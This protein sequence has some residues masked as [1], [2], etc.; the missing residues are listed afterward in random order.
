MKSTSKY[1][2]FRLFTLVFLFSIIDNQYLFAQAEDTVYVKKG[3]DEIAK[4]NPAAFNEAIKYFNKANEINPSNINAY[5]Y[6]GMCYAALNDFQS[7]IRELSKAL[8]LEPERTDILSL[9]I[10]MYG[11]SNEYSKALV[12][13]HKLV[14]LLPNNEM[15]YFNRCNTYYFLG[16]YQKAL[17][18]VNKALS[19][20]PDYEKALIGKKKILEKMDK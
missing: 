8:E 12:D 11:F 3:V 18:D 7:S 17:G 6:K 15:A 19:I 4:N 5:H 1:I 2:L 10:A 20:K 13:C 16:E 9:R 14:N